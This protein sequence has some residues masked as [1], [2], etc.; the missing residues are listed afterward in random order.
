M[1]VYNRTLNM[2]THGKTKIT[3]HIPVS[4]KTK[5]TKK[6]KKTEKTCSYLSDDKTNG[7]QLEKCCH[8]Q[9]VHLMK[10]PSPPWDSVLQY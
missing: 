2:Q 9:T 7:N 1:Y 4:C 3:E 5:K 10:K 8:Y 6:K